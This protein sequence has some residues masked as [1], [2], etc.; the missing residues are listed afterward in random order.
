MRLMKIVI[1]FFL[2]SCF[3]FP[4]AFAVERNAEVFST[5]D[6]K[7][8]FAREVSTLI[9][10]AWEKWQNL[11]S[12]NGVEVEGSSGLLSPGDLGEPV[13]N[14]KMLLLNFDTKGRSYEYIECVK[15][16]ADAVASSMQAWQRGYRNRVIPFPQGAACTFTLTKCMNIP[17]SLASGNSPGDKEMMEESL[18]NYMLYH[19]SFHSADIYVVYK[20]AAKAIAS[21]FNE[22]RFNC[23][24]V[25]ICASGGIAPRP[26]PMGTGPGPVSG[27]K[28]N[29]GR[30]KGKPF[31]SELM[32]ETMINYFKGQKNKP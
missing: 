10:E 8:S 5:F 16:V 14:K 28:G 30:L 26:A 19:T 3:I 13:L 21:C 7:E 6:E 31:C 4:A 22:W 15:T 17:V 24:I 27:A 23:S 2:V 29:R 25:D 18:Y 12:I 11:I 32:Y 20:A 9:G 1:V